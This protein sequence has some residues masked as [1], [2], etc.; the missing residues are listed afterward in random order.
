ML[1]CFE[2]NTRYPVGDVPICLFGGGQRVSGLSICGPVCAEPAPCARIV[3]QK[4][5]V[6]VP[7]TVT[8]FTT[9]NGETE[10]FCCGPATVQCL[11]VSTSPETCENC[12][13]D[14]D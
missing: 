4:A 9:D 7:V 6:C 5:S 14:Q 2:L 8:P 11:G 3:Y 1:A 10:V 13:S 12:L